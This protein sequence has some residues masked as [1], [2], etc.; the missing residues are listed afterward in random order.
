MKKRIRIIAHGSLLLLL[1]LLAAPL[2]WSA[3]NAALVSI[4]VTPVNATVPVGFT[5]QFT[6]IGIFSDG[7]TQDLTEQASWASGAPS[8]ATIQ[9][10]GHSGGIAI[11]VAPGATPISARFGKVISATSLTV[12]DASLVSIEVTP[13]FASLPKGYTR[14]FTAVGAF[15]DGSAEDLTADVKWS[16]NDTSVA[17][18]ANNDSAAGIA[19]GKHLGTAQIGARAGAINGAATVTVTGATLVSLEVIPPSPAL[20]AEGTL[21]LTATGT[22][23]DGA[24]LDMTDS[25]H[26]MSSDKSVATVSNADA[27]AGLAAGR[28]PGTTAITVRSGTVQGSTTLTVF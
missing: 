19:T 11:G 7:T 21:Q 15:S 4:E 12:T 18:V 28:Q 9:K 27:A 22:F 25:T 16:S 17:T 2:A 8:V 14:Q 24:T 20:P 6:A 10:G 5:R 1:A 26:W 23:S 3:P 13:A